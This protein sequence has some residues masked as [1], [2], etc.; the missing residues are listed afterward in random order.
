[1]L[2]RNAIALAPGQPKP[3]AAADICNICISL[4]ICK[5]LISISLKKRYLRKF[6]E[7]NNR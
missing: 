3:K 5:I 4:V 6:L 2:A 1:M 7:N